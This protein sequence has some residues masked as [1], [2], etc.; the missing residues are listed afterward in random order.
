MRK[1]SGK[2]NPYLKCVSLSKFPLSEE[3]GK[4]RLLFSTWGTTEKKA[5][6]LC[7]KGRGSI[8]GGRGTPTYSLR[9]GGP[10]DIARGPPS[11]RKEEK[12]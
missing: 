8:E 7:Q 3:N 1:N 4:A 2:K 12:G 11:M 5:C 10:P 9:K 6:I